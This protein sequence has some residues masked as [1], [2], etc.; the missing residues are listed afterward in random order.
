[1]DFSLN[2]DHVA[3]RD[4]VQR[5]CDGEYPAQHRGNPE[6]P[7]LDAQRWAGMAE[8]GLLGLPFD[9]EL[10]G[11]GQS[12]IELMLVAQELGRS[13][14]GGAW[15]SS[16]V[17]AGQLLAE[18]GTPAQCS[19]W[20]P[21]LASG[22]LRLALA[23]GEADSRY[24][25][26]RCA[27]TAR[28]VNGA[29]RIDGRKTLVLDGDRAH[30]FLVVAR[31]SGAVNDRH[32]LS[33]FAVEAKAPG[34]RV[35]PFTTLDGRR[36]A[37]VDFD[38]VEVGAA[39]IVGM[40][41]GALPVLDRAAAALCAEAAGAMEALLDLTAEHLKTRKQFG[42]PLAKFQVL[43]HRVADMLI[44]LEQA[45]SMACAAAMAVDAAEPEQRRR[46]VSAAKALIGQLGRQVGLTAIQ[47]HG[48][49]GMTDECRAGHYAKRL[50]VINQLFGDAS[51]HLQRIAGSAE[52]LN[53]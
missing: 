31:S 47:L 6:T 53:P 24:D 5:F 23:F 40:P 32:G 46:I 28:T 50:L 22:D 36:A 11:S 42:A 18:A 19:R 10:G 34:V 9:P 20:L 17:L 30:L 13:L 8:L 37:H 25:L 16:V 1:M 15:L 14:G 29:Y 12:A 33:I 51:H 39:A 43:Q 52:A 45:K 4:A 2:D 7:E 48:A 35:Q 49:M 21:A 44:A 27:T 26:A 41:G 3:L 38:A